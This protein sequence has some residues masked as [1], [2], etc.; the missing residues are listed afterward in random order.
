MLHDYTQGAYALKRRQVGGENSDLPNKLYIDGNGI[1][2]HRGY[3][4]GRYNVD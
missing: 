1:L 2:E 4:I 3:A